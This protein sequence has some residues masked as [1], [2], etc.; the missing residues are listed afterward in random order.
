MDRPHI[1]W[2]A[3]T[4]L[5]D[6]G[7]GRIQSL[8]PFWINEI[9]LVERN[10][11]QVTRTLFHLLRVTLNNRDKLGPQLD[12]GAVKEYSLVFCI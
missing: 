2:I 7:I 1:A 11:N 10:S 4:I 3:L 12:H 9:L 6:E 8:L 5:L